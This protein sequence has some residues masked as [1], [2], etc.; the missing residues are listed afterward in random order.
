MAEKTIKKKKQSRRGQRDIR[1]FESERIEGFRAVRNDIENNYTYKERTC[2]I[3]GSNRGET[4]FEYEA[5]GFY[6]PCRICKDCGLVYNYNIPSEEN[7]MHFYKNH[8]RLL[9]NGAKEIGENAYKIDLERGENILKFLKRNLSHDITGN[10]II[11]LGCGAG[12][13][14]ETFNNA[15]LIASGID[16]NPQFIKQIK[17]KGLEA[18]LSSLEDFCLT[19]KEV[20][21]IVI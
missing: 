6:L 20:Y 10:K 11:E 13:A 1:K 21:D 7:Y 12:G 16:L 3:C 14:L 18:E 8:Y 17:E 9:Y 4:L 15:G 5:Y 19:N 2:P